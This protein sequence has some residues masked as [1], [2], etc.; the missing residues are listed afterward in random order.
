MLGRGPLGASSGC[1]RWTVLCGSVPY[2]WWGG[3]DRG[4]LLPAS[5]P[6]FSTPREP[7][8][9]QTSMASGR[10]VHSRGAQSSSGRLRGAVGPRG[11]QPGP[12]AC[13]LPWLRPLL[14]PTLAGVRAGCQNQASLGADPSFHQLSWWRAFLFR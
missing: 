12:R 11:G 10:F 1:D 4:R 7:C 8:S 2:L 6:T 14:L 3:H 5:L 9:I 13:S